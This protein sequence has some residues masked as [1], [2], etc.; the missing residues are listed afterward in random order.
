MPDSPSI[1]IQQLLAQ[2]DWVRRL[3]RRLVRDEARADDLE[4]Q[5]WLAA[6][7]RPPTG[8]T[9]RAWLGQVM[10]NL[11]GRMRRT[12]V[13][14]D[15]RERAAARPERLPGTGDVVAQAE[16]HN[17]LV[18][19][20]L[21]LD[22]PYRESLLLRHFENLPPREIAARMGVSV[23]TVRSRVRRGLNQIRARFD[24]EHGGDRRSWCLA[25]I[26]LATQGQHVAAATGASAAASGT[27]VLLMSAKSKLLV[28]AAA[29]LLVAGGTWWFLSDRDTAP[30]SEPSTVGG[31]DEGGGPA[32]LESNGGIK[33]D[34]TLADASEPEVQDTPPPF[35][36]G[37]AWVRI[38]RGTTVSHTGIAGAYARIAMPRGVV[39]DTECDEWGRAEIPAEYVGA[40]ASLF[41]L[42]METKCFVRRQIK[43]AAGELLVLLPERREV[44]VLLKDEFGRVVSAA[45]AKQRYEAAG[46][47][48][49]VR[50]VSHDALT[51][52]DRS[53]S[54]ENM[55]GLSDGLSQPSM[56]RFEDGRVLL[57]I[58]PGDGYWR[59]L[60]ERPAAA[61]DMTPVF[62]VAAGA[63]VRVEMQLPSEVQG[64]RIRA[65]SADDGSVLKNATIQP[66]YEIGDD[67]AFVPGVARR[68]DAQGEATIPKFDAGG[69]RGQRAP[70]WWITTADRAVMIG[71]VLIRDAV[72]GEVVEVKVP[73]TASVRGH[74]Y[75]RNGKP[76]VGRSIISTRK[77]RGVRT[78]V[79][80]D[81][82]YRLD[83]V[84]AGGWGRASVFLIEDLEAAA[85]Q[86]GE[87]KLTPGEVGT[88]DFGRATVASEVGTIEGRVT[89]GGQPVP[90]L[91]VVVRPETSKEGMVTGVTDANGRYRLEGLEPGTR[92]FMVILGDYRVSDDF[93]IRSESGFTVE[94][95]QLQTLDFDLPDGVVEVVL[96][97]DETGKPI[98]GGAAMA[99]A[100]AREHGRDLFDGFTAVIG[101]SESVDKQGVARLQALPRGEPLT[102]RYGAPGYARSE[103]TDVTAGTPDEPKRIEI[104][105]RKQD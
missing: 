104:R 54:L 85:F 95:G 8:N 58:T 11:A 15:R 39:F 48:P 4:Q 13:R 84:A 49:L 47:R 68:T 55:F 93:S 88:H 53:R 19:A 29:V 98:Q 81:G 71:S 17:R 50:L 100:T 7:D 38:A 79:G 23:E 25:L 59:I 73:R 101:W 20:V 16:L 65:V 3:A 92:R 5:T 103:R 14:V 31:T 46:M 69:R 57:E 61:P 72:A 97:D 28:V 87:L 99:R 105:L 90:N 75:L 44:E 43:I 60:M 42:E 10:R 40:T 66:Y 80:P 89:A 64:A 70:A 41:A 96:L 56:L 83:G 63:P 67:A 12:E 51:D 74:A 2:R 26:P 45:D 1:P 76:A 35:E 9:P 78:K 77:G 91:L 86:M 21:A 94:A 22:P 6:L 33:P 34:P 30:A 102:V 37:A 52:G 36:E 32:R 62:E 82:G 24:D 27:G 18:Q